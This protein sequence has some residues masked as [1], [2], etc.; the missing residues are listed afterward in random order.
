MEWTIIG[1]TPG[2]IFKIAQLA[3]NSQGDSQ[4]SDYVLIGASALPSAPQSLYKD[5]LQSNKT[6]MTISWD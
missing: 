3:V 6:A 1:L 5:S 4:L 2:V